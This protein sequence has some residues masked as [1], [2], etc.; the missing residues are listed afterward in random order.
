MLMWLLTVFPGWLSQIPYIL[1]TSWTMLT[2]VS[3]MGQYTLVAMKS[4][5]NI[6]VPLSPLQDFWL[7]D[8]F[9]STCWLELRLGRD[10]AE[11]GL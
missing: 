11:F 3:A 9:L 5:W 4:S 2:R 10:R 7:Q 1:G 6:P 8:A